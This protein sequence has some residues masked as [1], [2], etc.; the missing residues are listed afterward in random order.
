MKEADLQMFYM[1]LE[2]VAWDHFEGAIEQSGEDQ[3]QA[4]EQRASEE[5]VYG[6]EEEPGPNSNNNN[7]NTFTWSGPSG[8][9]DCT[10][11]RPVGPAAA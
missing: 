2:P 10:G 3:F 6:S 8:V 1:G 9:V 11:Q 7:N 4:I 5:K